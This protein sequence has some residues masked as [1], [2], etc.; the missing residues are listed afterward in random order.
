MRV[1]RGAHDHVDG[2]GN[3]RDAFLGLFHDF[4]GGIDQIG[5]IEGLA[6]F[7]ARGLQEGVRDAAAHDEPIHALGEIVEHFEL[8]GHL[9][10][11]DNGQQ[12]VLGSVQ[13][14]GERLQF[15]GHEQTHAGD[16]REA[17][18]AFRGGL[19]A[20]GRGEGVHDVNVPEGGQLA[21]QFLVVLLLALVEAHVLAEYAVAGLDA[22]AV[23]IV[24]FQTDR[25]AEQFFKASGDRGE[26][27]FFGK[28][29][30]LGTAQMREHN[31]ARALLQ[32]H[33]QRRHGGADA[34]VAGDFSVL[35]R[36]VEVF[37]EDNGLPL[38]IDIGHESDVHRNSSLK[39]GLSTLRIGRQCHKNGF[40][41]NERRLSENHM[42]HVQVREAGPRGQVRQ[43]AMAAP[44]HE[45]FP[46]FGTAQQKRSPTQGGIARRRDA[47]PQ[48]RRQKAQSF[49]RLAGGIFPER[50]AQMHAGH[51]P[52]LQPGGVQQALEGKGKGRLDLE[53]FLHVRPKERQPT[54]QGQ[55]PARSAARHGGKETQG[56]RRGRTLGQAA[57]RLDETDP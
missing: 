28:D 33:F 18:R 57:C 27:G 5:F 52:A 17:D 11:A 20:V 44:A 15:G 39:R 37:A 1:Q 29:A 13:D 41:A 9:G 4:G 49:Q 46:Q 35:D 55:A 34:L 19:R 16:L 3:G 43:R 51:I 54:R 6:H 26:G 12:R 45:A 50:P 22:H 56:Q 53:D 31:D 7:V 24:A 40:H 42:T 36:D 47:G 32:S 38:H 21:G 23:Q 48:A 25:H 2:Q 8:G 10:A 30:F 14:A